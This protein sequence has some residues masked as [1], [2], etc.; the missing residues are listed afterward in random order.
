[1]QPLVRQTTSCEAEVPARCERVSESTLACSDFAP[2]QAFVTWAIP[3]KEMFEE[4]GS[5]AHTHVVVRTSPMPPNHLPH[6]D[7]VDVNELSDNDECLPTT[8]VVA[9]S[10]EPTCGC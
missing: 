6:R 9:V 5:N 7:R 3:F 2:H 10:D 4:N 1:V 8:V